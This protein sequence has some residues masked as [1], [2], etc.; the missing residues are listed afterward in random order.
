MLT[1]VARNLR[2]LAARQTQSGDRVDICVVLRDPT[3]VARTLELVA[4]PV[5]DVT[6]LVTRLTRILR[7]NVANR[8]F[9]LSCFVLDPLLEPSERTLVEASVHPL[10]V[11]KIFADVAQI[12]QCEDWFLELVGVLNGPSRR[13]LDDVSE[14]VLVVVGSIVNLPLCGVALLK[15]FQRREHLLAKVPSATTVDEQWVSRSSSLAG[16]ARKQ[17]GFANVESH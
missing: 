4:V 6:P 13:L 8:N 15:L 12:S 2:F 10:A 5:P 9:S 1:A 17:V 16:T 14:Y 7:S 3:L 11:I